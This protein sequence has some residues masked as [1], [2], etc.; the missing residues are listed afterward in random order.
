MTPSTLLARYR[1]AILALTAIAAGCTIFYIHNAFWSLDPSLQPSSQTR[2]RANTLR[3]SN[4]Q[5]RNRQSR[6]TD[7]SESYPGGE[8]SGLENGS[9]ANVRAETDIEPE[10][11]LPR[12]FADLQSEI[13]ALESRRNPAIA[14][15]DL[16]WR[17]DAESGDINEEKQSLFNLLF[18]ITEEQAMK[19]G[20]VHRGVA[21]N[22]CNTTHIKG[23][24]YRCANCIDFDL[25]EQCEAM[26][27]HPTTHLFYKIRIPAPFLGNPRQPQPVWYPGKPSAVSHLLPKSAVAHLCKVTGFQAPEVHALWEQFRCLANAEYLHDPN[28]YYLAIDRRTFDKCFVPNTTLRPIPPNLICD[29]LF[30]FYDTDRDGLISF[31]EFIQGLSSLT[32]Q[33]SYHKRKKIF[34]G[35]DIN[36]D[37]HV[38]RKDFLRMFRAFYALSKELTR[39]IVT[40]MDEDTYEGG[41]ARDIVTGSQPISSAFSGA[42]PLGERSRAGE[43]KRLDENGDKVLINRDISTVRD[44]GEDIEDHNEILADLAETAKF[45][46]IGDEDIMKYGESMLMGESRLWPPPYATARDVDDALHRSIALE[47]VEHP[48]DREKVR[49]AACQRIANN[50]EE[51][52]LVRERGVRQRWQRQQFYIDEEN[53]AIPPDELKL[54]ETFETQ[55]ASR[56]SRSSSKVRFQDDLATDEDLETRSVTSMSS[57]S[58]PVGERWGGY[59]VPEAEKDVAREILY[60]V[61]QEGLNDLLDP[62][63]RQREDLAIMARRTLP[64][65]T[66]FRAL[67]TAYSDDQIQERVRQAMNRLQSVWRNPITRPHK[68][69]DPLFDSFEVLFCVND[70]RFLDTEFDINQSANQAASQPT[71]QADND[72]NNIPA[73]TIDHQ[74]TSMQ[75]RNWVDSTSALSPTNLNFPNLPTPSDERSLDFETGLHN[76]EDTQTQAVANSESSLH[77][78][79]APLDLTLPQN[80]PN[81]PSL[82]SSQAATTSSPSNG[83]PTISKT[84]QISLPSRTSSSSQDSSSLT[85][86]SLPRM[87]VIDDIHMHFLIACDQIDAEDKLPRRGPGRINFAEFNEIMTGSKGSSLGFIGEWIEMARF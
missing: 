5:R 23:I 17:D 4:A 53:G 6:N 32:K 30:A 28:R 67:L 41:A 69:V 21:C 83:S 14:D 59:E 19:D 85:T 26:Q 8:Q 37:G 84:P 27:V 50:E 16:S 57:R 80:R 79:N 63:F 18:R 49:R 46:N 86:S 72:S 78:T 39:E 74:S 81:S 64:E 73:N 35:Y 15:N 56:R 3:R 7:H 25:C 43:G 44:S 54:D 66:H 13:D 68:G 34:E 65:R 29:R 75:P 24:R 58:I 40:A 70:E 60:Q 2:P 22:S 42:I 36:D 62:I 10:P 20:Y 45:G 9:T 55:Q 77:L 1:P 82:A 71:M 38:D 51:R 61:T 33:K 47:D 31:N 76:L 11:S 87:M 12:R 52:R 48:S